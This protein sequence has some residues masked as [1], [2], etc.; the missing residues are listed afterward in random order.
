MGLFIYS[1]G[2]SNKRGCK[3]KTSKWLLWI[4]IDR[5]RNI[6]NIPKPPNSFDGEQE[7]ML[8]SIICTKEC[9]LEIL[10]HWKLTKVLA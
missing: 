8:S 4:G 2:H 9:V 1:T 5:E 10:G 7:Q 3:N 6:R